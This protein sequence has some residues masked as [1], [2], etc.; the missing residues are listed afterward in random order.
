MNNIISD[1]VFDLVSRHRA[2]PKEKL[3][4][5]TRLRE[6]LGMEGDD[7]VEFLEEFSKR[8]DV[9]LGKF[10]FH[11]HF[12]PEVAYNPL[13]VLIDFIFKRPPRYP[14]L[15]KYPVTVKHLILVAENKKWFLPERTERS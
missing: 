2:V 13:I 14:D 7:A 6:D 12:G 15:G 5:E 8:F 11:K 1:R 9:D 10:E 3:G 4:P